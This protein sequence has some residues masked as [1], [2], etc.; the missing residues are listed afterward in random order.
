[1][2]YP[3]FTRHLCRISDERLQA[4]K[5]ELAGLAYHRHP[6]FNQPVDRLKSGI[7]PSS[8]RDILQTLAPW[9]P[10]NAYHTYE[11]LRLNPG[12]SVSEHSDIC[13]AHNNRLWMAAHYHKVH[14]PVWTNESCRSGHRRTRG[15]APDYTAMDEGAAVLYNDYVWHTGENQGATDRV[16]ICLAY[17][18]PK[19]LYPLSTEESV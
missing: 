6:G 1:M 15:D 19:W 8:I 18:D 5:T 9:F 12:G 13:G 11:V 7:S 4:L 3:F 10:E 16:H 2:D 14:I 17:F